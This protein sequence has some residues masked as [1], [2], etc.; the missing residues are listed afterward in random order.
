MRR[1]GFVVAVAV[2]TLLALALP[3]WSAPALP[4]AEQAE[5][6]RVDFNGDGFADLAVGAPGEAVGSLVGAGAL[7]VLNGSATGLQ[8]SADVFFQG[9]GGVAGTAEHDDG[10]GAA[11]AKGDFND[12]GFFDLAVGVPGEVVGGVLDAGVITVLFGSGGGITI[13]GRQTLFQGSGGITGSAESGDAFAGHRPP[14]QR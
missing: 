6:D 7:N 9:S 4:R 13:A 10:F 14:G 3:G 11:V 5:A 1:A 12:D 8:P 2:A